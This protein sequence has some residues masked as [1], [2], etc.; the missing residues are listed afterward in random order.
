MDPEV[1]KGKIKKA[2]L[3]PLDGETVAPALN[4]VSVKHLTPRKARYAQHMNYIVQFKSKE[5]KLA[6]LKQIKDLFNTIVH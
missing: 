4:P 1:L 5:I 6:H 2:I 3:N